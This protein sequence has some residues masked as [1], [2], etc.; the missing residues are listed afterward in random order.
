MKD[1][2]MAP[3]TIRALTPWF[4]SGIS[5]LFVLTGVVSPNLTPEV[6]LSILALASTALG[7]AAG[8]SQQNKPAQI[9]NSDIQSV[10]LGEKPNT[11]RSK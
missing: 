10:N 2:I 11:E 9:Q 7:G 8:L 1:C 3:D 6:R 5:L 4:L